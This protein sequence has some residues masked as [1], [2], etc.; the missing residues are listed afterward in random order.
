YTR[1]SGIWICPDAKPANIL[2]ARSGVPTKNGGL[3]RLTTRD[4]GRS[5]SGSN[6]RMTREG[7][8]ASEVP[9]VKPGLY[10][11]TLIARAGSPMLISAKER[12]VYRLHN[13]EAA[14]ARMPHSFF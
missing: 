4:S 5:T 6:I 8:P 14:Y 13:F 11:I 9:P 12:A 10:A 3:N 2:P 7:F 1:P